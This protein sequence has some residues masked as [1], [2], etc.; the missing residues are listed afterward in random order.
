MDALLA[1]VGGQVWNMAIRSG[2]AITTSFA[3]QQGARLLKT[4]DDQEIHGELQSQQ[5]LLSDKIKA[6]IAR[7]FSLSG[8]V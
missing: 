4:V 6:G 3:V 2:I 8:R 5:K 1:S 7:L